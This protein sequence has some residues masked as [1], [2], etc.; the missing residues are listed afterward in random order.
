MGIWVVGSR[1]RWFVPESHLPPVA[2]LREQGIVL[3]LEK[4]V[5]DLFLFAERL[6]LQCKND[7]FQVGV[8]GAP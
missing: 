8:S 2:L 6:R 1:G 5:M 3:V 4:D 7:Q